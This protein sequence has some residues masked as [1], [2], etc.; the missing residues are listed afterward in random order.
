M[1]WLKIVDYT[2]KFSIIFIFGVGFLL[3]ILV[4]GECQVNVVK[5]YRIAIYVSTLFFAIYIIISIVIFI[6]LFKALKILRQVIFYKGAKQSY[7][8]TTLHIFMFSFYSIG[9][10][11]IPF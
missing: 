10:S 1:K 9:L 2:A 6:V 4:I 11:I 5:C 7:S 8:M 3:S